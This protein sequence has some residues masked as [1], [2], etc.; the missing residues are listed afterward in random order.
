MTEEKTAL[1]AGMLTGLR[2]AV[3][4][5]RERAITT[6]V[7]ETLLWIAS[8]CDHSNELQQ[9]MG[10]Q[11]RELRRTLALLQGRRYGAGSNRHRDSPVCLVRS[12]P[13]PH[14]KG[15]QWVLTEDGTEFLRSCKMVTIAEENT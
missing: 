10:I 5:T 7:P 11:M 9:Q 4:T 8:G 6:V 13:H 1:V 15:L 12:R 2:Q 14:R 3:G